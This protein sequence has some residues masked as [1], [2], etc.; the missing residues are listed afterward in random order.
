MISLKTFH[1]FFVIASIILTIFY[2][3]FEIQTPSSPGI[4]SNV[5]SITSFICSLALLTY[6]I[7]I[8]KKFRN[9]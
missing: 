1:L 7:S 4:I 3:V 5:L 6:F 8:I 2:G 9:I